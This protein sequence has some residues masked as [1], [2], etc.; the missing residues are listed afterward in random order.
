M[1]REELIVAAEIAFERLMT[2]TRGL[3]P[4]L[5]EEP[6]AEGKWSFKDLAAH[7]VF[8]DGLTLR[9]LE[10]LNYGR[11]FDWS[12]YANEDERNAQAVERLRPQNVKRVLTELRLTHSTMTEAIRLVAADKLLKDDSV[13]NWLIENAVRH[14][15]HHI[16]KVEQWAERMRKEGRAPAPL[17]ILG[18]A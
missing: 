3:P 15:E 1:T 6:M 10:E 14:Y 7:F 2:P 11:A 18:G 17:N 8:W 12:P 13:P 16:P 9:A 5:M 4:A